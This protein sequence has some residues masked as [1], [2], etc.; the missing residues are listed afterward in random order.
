MTPD[1][2]II[3]KNKV[4]LQSYSKKIAQ[5]WKKV[6]SMIKMG[7]FMKKMLIDWMGWSVQE[8]KWNLDLFKV[9]N[10]IVW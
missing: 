9:I 3:I 2:L 6:G 1:F 7:S 4:V 5:E 10:L 8:N